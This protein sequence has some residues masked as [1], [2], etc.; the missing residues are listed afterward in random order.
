MK[1]A[2]HLEV[3]LL[4]AT[5]YRAACGVWSERHRYTTWGDQVTCAKCRKAMGCAP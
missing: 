5:T 3:E 1:G 4:Y 2:V